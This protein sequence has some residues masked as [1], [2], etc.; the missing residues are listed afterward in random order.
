MSD[1]NR[2]LGLETESRFFY[3]M[4]SVPLEMRPRWLREIREATKQEDAI[5]CDGFAQLDIG[6]VPLQI[7]SSINKAWPYLSKYRDKHK[8]V[9]VVAIEPGSNEMDIRKGTLEGLAEIREHLLSN[10]PGWK[11]QWNPILTYSY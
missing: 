10:M 11:V 5:G 6:V 3:A 4:Q 1:M 8:V 2:H 7:K 9:L